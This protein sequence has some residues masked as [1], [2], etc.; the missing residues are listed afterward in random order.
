MLV[1]WLVFLFDQGAPKMA[2]PPESP[3][4]GLADEEP[5]LESD[6]D[7]FGIPECLKSDPDFINEKPEGN[8]DAEPA[9][10]EAV[11]AG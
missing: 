6:S 4:L 10:P 2:R 11:L 3:V 7:W 1:F 9:A 5:P 8:N